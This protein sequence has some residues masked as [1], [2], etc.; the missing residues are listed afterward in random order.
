MPI[1]SATLRAFLAACAALGSVLVADVAHAQSCTALKAEYAKAQRA[2]RHSQRYAAAL[3]RQRAQMG[4][5]EDLL[6][7]HSCRVR[8]DRTC[9]TLRS[10]YREMERNRK[11][12]QAGLRKVAGPGKRRKL[13]ARIARA[14][15]PAKRTKPAAAREASA[16]VR[17]DR[18]TTRRWKSPRGTFSTLCVR[19][20][21]GFAFPVSL[22]TTPKGFGADAQACPALC[23]GT[24]TRLYARRLKQ[25][26][27]DARDVETGAKYGSLPTAFRFR[28]AYDD[29]CRCRT[30]RQQRLDFGKPVRKP[31]G[32]RRESATLRPAPKVR[33][34]GT[35]Y[36]KQ[37]TR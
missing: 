8:S 25:G 31:A 33:I 22:S 28:E 37:R 15:G 3:Q 32:D 36:F 29:A 5:V 9:R 10:S 27:D 13:R 16:V 2:D 24:A 11:R 7:R 35:D 30:G 26:L 21:D 1:R 14:C 6:R 20:C 23:P 4:R 18:E 34:V 12:L 17:S 19:M